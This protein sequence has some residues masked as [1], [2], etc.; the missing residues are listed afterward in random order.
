[1]S[2]MRITFL[3][4]LSLLAST[5]MSCP[6]Y[7]T[8]DTDQRYFVV[9]PHGFDA[10]EIIPENT[11]LIDPT[12]HGWSKY[13]TYETLHFYVASSE[14]AESFSLTYAL[15][16]N[17]CISENTELTISDIKGFVEN[18]TERF[19]VKKKKQPATDQ[20]KHRHTHS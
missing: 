14:A 7:I 15:T 11:M 3:G 19:S 9:N 10:V 1:M 4:V 6:M 2:Y 12:I 8:N 18:P 16:E 20:Q 13:F 17:Y 5:L